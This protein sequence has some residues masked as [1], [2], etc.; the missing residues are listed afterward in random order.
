M[1]TTTELLPNLNAN[2]LKAFA[3][4]LALP[5]TLTRKPE[6]I[7]ELD[8][9]VRENLSNLLAHCS[10]TEK[11]LLA[12]AAHNSGRVDPIAFRAKYGKACPLPDNPYWGTTITLLL[13]LLEYQGG[14][15]KMP[16]SI[17]ERVRGLL[18]KPAPAAIQVVGNLPKEYTPPQETWRKAAPRPIHVHEGERIVFPELRSVLK[19]VQAGKLKVTDKGG[20]PTEDTVRLISEVLVVPDFVV[21]P[22]PE[23]TTEYT[24]HA[25]ALRAHAWGV[26][27]QQCEWAKAKSGRLALTSDGQKLLA[28]MEVSEFAAGVEAFLW[29]DEFDELNRI[30]H[31]RGQTGGGK[32]YLTSPADRRPEITESVAQWPV[33]QWI[34]FD[35]AACFLL[36][37]GHRFEVTTADHT[38]Y[39]GELQYGLLGGHGGQI[40]RQYLRAFLFES[41]ATL[42]LIDIA[43]VYPHH[44]WPELGNSW[45]IDELS[46]CSRYDGL[47]YV[48]LNALGA[49]CLDATGVYQPAVPAEPRGWRV[50]PNREIAL[51]DGQQVSPA[52]RHVLAL[53][54]TEKSEH[55]WELDPARILDHLESGGKVEDALQFLESNCAPPIPETVQTMLSDLARRGTVVRAVEEAL[56]I[57]VADE[58]TA[59]LIAHDSQAGKYCRL[60]G[61][62]RLAVPRRNS[63]AFRSAIK[64]LGFIIPDGRFPT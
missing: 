44:L 7:T 27:V 22:P 16:P 8:R 2:V 23:M 14:E 62:G 17:G 54:A 25:G 38:L 37:T 60:A 19:L 39:F 15:W 11:Q 55:L 59:A 33:N 31:I 9:Y 35:Q 40:N 5:K 49:Y 46:F 26:L 20:R 45:G 18:E 41:L 63:R 50:L 10:V 64:K 47:L 51:I 58:T 24:E 52:D 32:R 42:G 57:E 13:L 28:S 36:A 1:A 61:G 56:L 12:E 30:N 34:A 43:Y 53:F 48:R 3:R 4:Q 29:D 21:D 6:L